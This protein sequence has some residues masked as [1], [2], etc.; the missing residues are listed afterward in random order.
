MG[1]LDTV[2]FDMDDEEFDRLLLLAVQLAHDPDL[3]RIEPATFSELQ[4]HSTIAK[5]VLD[6]LLGN[7]TDATAVSA[8]FSVIQRAAKS[9]RLL[10]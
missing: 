9:S 4:F 10:G 6:C 2:G 8:W 3:P 1:T 7:C 5:N